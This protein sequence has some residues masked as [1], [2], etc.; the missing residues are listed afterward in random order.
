MNQNESSMLLSHTGQPQT[1]LGRINMCAKAR[2]VIS[3]WEESE[4][5]AGP[6]GRSSSEMASQKRP[7]AH[8]LLIQAASWFISMTYILWVPG[9]ELLS[10]PDG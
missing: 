4:V 2:W 9:T 10:Y 5:E 3:R 7:L 8:T 6:G 1:F